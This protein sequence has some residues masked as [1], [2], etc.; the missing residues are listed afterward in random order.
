SFL[1]S[2]FSYKTFDV[3]V[4]A[5]GEQPLT[6]SP[7]ANS[8]NYFA[9]TR[10]RMRRLQWQETYYAR[11]VT[12]AGQHSFKIGT[13]LDYTKISARFRNSSIL[14]RRN[15]GTLAQRIDFTAPSATAL[16]VGEVTAFAQ[17]HWSVNH[18]LTI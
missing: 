4:F 3:D 12:L 11:P 9:D 8:G 1:S 6:L 14:I 7:E 13:E 17:D 18:K 15:N 10:R 5:Q 16:Q 2:A